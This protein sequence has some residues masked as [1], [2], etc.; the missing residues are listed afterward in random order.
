MLLRRPKTVA[1]FWGGRRQDGDNELTMAR[2]SVAE[3]GSLPAEHGDLVPY[4]S[5]VIKRSEGRSSA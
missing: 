4:M 1:T 5:G 3:S 2:R